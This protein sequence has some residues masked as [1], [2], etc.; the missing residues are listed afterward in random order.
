MLWVACE[1]RKVLWFVAIFLG[2]RAGLYAERFTA[3]P[4]RSGGLEGTPATLPVFFGIFFAVV[5]VVF[6]AGNALLNG[7]NSR[8]THA[9]RGYDSRD[10]G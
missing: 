9:L 5:F 1:G 6:V 3:V 7:K 8:L 4:L 10:A 2:H